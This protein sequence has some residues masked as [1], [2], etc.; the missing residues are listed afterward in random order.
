MEAVRPNPKFEAS[1]QTN[2]GPPAPGDKADPSLRMRLRTETRPQHE[3]L[4]RLAGELSFSRF[5]DMLSFI[6]AN[7]LAYRSLI[8]VAG[9]AEPMLAQRLDRARDVLESLDTHL[10]HEAV[11]IDTS[12]IEPI[13]LSYVVAGSSLGARLIAQQSEASSDPRVHAL[14][15][16]LLD[17]EMDRC[18]RGLADELRNMSGQDS[19]AEEILVS[20]ANCFRVFQQAFEHVLDMTGANHGV[21]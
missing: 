17:P 3:Q 4:D 14:A 6:Q 11:A 13:G 21:R 5:E 15:E 12:G 9:D 20:A 16:F 8:A 18:W 10:N 7:C 1:V 19:R 2:A